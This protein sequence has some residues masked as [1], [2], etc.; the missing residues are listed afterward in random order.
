MRREPIRAGDEEG[1]KTVV[2]VR[3]TGGK[4]AVSLVE[5]PGVR[6]LMREA[7]PV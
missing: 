1:G 7:D 4:Y 2:P 6:L 3:S 5:T